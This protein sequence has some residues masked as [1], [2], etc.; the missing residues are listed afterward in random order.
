MVIQDDTIDIFLVNKYDTIKLKKIQSIFNSKTNDDISY[1]LWYKAYNDENWIYTN[2]IY[3]KYCEYCFL[4]I[5]TKRNFRWIKTK[6]HVTPIIKGIYLCAFLDSEKIK[7]LP[8]INYEYTDKFFEYPLITGGQKIGR[9]TYLE[10]FG[11]KINYTKNALLLINGVK[12]LNGDY[13]LNAKPGLY[14]IQLFIDTHYIKTNINIISDKQKDILNKMYKDNYIYETGEAEPPKNI[15][16]NNIKEET[17]T[18]YVSKNFLYTLI[19]KKINNQN[20]SLIKVM[21][22]RNYGNK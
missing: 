21:E 17:A 20:N 5:N 11:P 2:I 10:G 22:F 18:N 1:S 12:V 7:I 13:L 8:T 19:G 9:A 4:C 3:K 16:E 14:N 15:K 6:L